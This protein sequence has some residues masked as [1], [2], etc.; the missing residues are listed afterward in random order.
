[1]VSIS[2]QLDAPSDDLSSLSFCDVD[3]A[4]LE[5]WSAELPLA[6]TNDTAAQLHRAVTEVSRLAVEPR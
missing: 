4:A 3:A 2:I 1:M 5:E 6:N